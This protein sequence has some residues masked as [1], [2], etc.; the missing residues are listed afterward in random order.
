MISKETFLNVGG[1]NEDMSKYE[2]VDLSLEAI[3]KGYINVWT[4]FAKIRYCKD[5]IDDFANGDT[6]KFVTKWN[7]DI[8]KNDPYYHNNWEKFKL[9]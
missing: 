2:D 1:F 8:L 4:C 6:E 9:V 3:K 5:S 7:D